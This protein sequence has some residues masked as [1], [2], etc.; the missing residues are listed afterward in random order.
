[1]NKFI[2]LFLTRSVDFLFE[3]ILYFYYWIQ[4]LHVAVSISFGCVVILLIAYTDWYLPLLTISWLITYVAYLLSS[5]V[6][7]WFSY[8][9]ALCEELLNHMEDYLNE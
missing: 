9:I 7:A 2:S 3:C 8:S 1:M 4:V 6:R 5:T